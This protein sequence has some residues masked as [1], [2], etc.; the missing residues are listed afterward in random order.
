MTSR[1]AHRAAALIGAA[2]L[3]AALGACGSSDSVMNLAVGDCLSSSDLTNGT[4]ETA[5]TINCSEPHDAEVYASTTLPD[6]DYPGT[7][8]VQS[9]AED[10]CLP[11]FEDFIGMAYV[12]SEF[13]VFPLSPSEA[14]WTSSDDREILCVVV[15]STPVTGTLKGSAR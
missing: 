12:D 8:A 15:S 4:V 11:A 10:F 1:L 2:G 7:T 6:G 9:S 14:G 3:V 5:P 13:D